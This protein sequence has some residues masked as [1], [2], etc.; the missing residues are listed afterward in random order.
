MCLQEEAD[1][2]PAFHHYVS[3]DTQT[4]ALSLELPPNPCRPDPPSLG[5]Q[6]R[7]TAWQA[8]PDAASGSATHALY[9]PQFAR[10]A[11]KQWRLLQSGL[12]RGIYVLHSQKWVKSIVCFTRVILA[13]LAIRVI[14]VCE[15][16]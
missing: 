11:Q 13:I 12:P 8:Q 6:F 2:D 1:A 15:Y 3:A 7:L 14:R 16:L 4:Q 9:G 10:T 5:P